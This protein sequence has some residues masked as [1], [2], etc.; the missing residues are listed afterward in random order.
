VNDEI[1]RLRIGR[2]VEAVFQRLI[3]CELPGLAAGD[4]HGENFNLRGIF[5]AVADGV[6]DEGDARA[7]R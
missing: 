6:G 3:V 1:K 5:H 2:P 7:V 4:G